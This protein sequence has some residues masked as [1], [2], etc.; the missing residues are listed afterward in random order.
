MMNRTDPNYL[1]RLLTLLLQLIIDVSLVVFFI[2]LAVVVAKDRPEGVILAFTCAG[3]TFL[4]M[5]IVCGS[6][7]VKERKR[8]KARL[9]GPPM[10]EESENCMHCDEPLLAA[11]KENGQCIDCE[12]EREEYE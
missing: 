11:E 2:I 7:Y 10:L 6:F 4:I 9:V 1:Y 5:F 3:L 8:Y 12:A